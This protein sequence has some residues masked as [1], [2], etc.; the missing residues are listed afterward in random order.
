MLRERLARNHLDVDGAFWG[1]NDIWLNLVFRDWNIEQILPNIHCPV[2][3]IQGR[4]D[5]Y[6][7]LEQ[8][9]RI[10]RQTSH[11]ELLS[12]ENCRHS[13]RRVHPEDVLGRATSW[14]KDL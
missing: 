5:E 14:L 3:A 13:P 7:T 8:V 9:E 6:G 10:A 2:L 12:L 1:W 4:Q 11:F